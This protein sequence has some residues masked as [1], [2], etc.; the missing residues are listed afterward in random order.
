MKTTALDKRLA[1]L[2]VRK[3]LVSAEIRDELLQ[4]CEREG[5]SFSQRIV[6]DN[7]VEEDMIISTVA[8]TVDL[9]PINLSKITIDEEVSSIVT[10]DVAKYYVVLPVAKIGNALTIAVADPFDIPKLDDLKIVTGCELQPVVST[11][12]AILRAISEQ[13]NKSEKDMENLMETMANPELELTEIDNGDDS[14][15]LSELTAESGDS[16]VIK[17]VNMLVYQ[18]IKS[19]ASDIHVEPYEKRVRVRYRIDGKCVEQISPPKRM[20]NAIS[21]RIKIMSSLDIAERRIPQDGKFQLRVEGRQIDFR[22]SLLPIVHGEKIV[23]RILDSSSLKLSLDD[24]GFE[25]SA[26]DSFR[27][28]VKSPYG[29]L[30]VTGPTGSGKSTTLYSSVKEV[31]N[32]EDNIITV[33]DPVEYQLEGVNQVPVNVKTGLTFEAALRSILRQDPDTVMIGEIRDKI[34]AEIAVKAALTGHLVFSTLHTND[35]P[36]TITRLIDMGIDNFLVASSVLLVAAQRLGRKLC[37]ECKRPMNPNPPKKR[38]LEVGYTEEEADNT[39]L[40]LYEPGSCPRCAS[41]F[42]GRFALLEALMINE[43]IRRLIIDGKSAIEIKKAALENGMITLRR[44]GLLNAMRGKT[45]VD[46]VLSCTMGDF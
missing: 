18:A 41:G 13:F 37:T 7:I 27:K 1:S 19:G 3:G 17:L 34:T 29:M 8:E 35:A 45:S 42:K 39:D 10:E 2:L 38:L 33:E 4:K 44:C 11:T 31:L 6:D 43:D 24:L 16:P 25:P 26:L 28:A 21:S 5:V 32:V 22:V 12:Q 14:V 15:D 40:Q 46:A 20:Q 30:L 36:S 23:I 9:P